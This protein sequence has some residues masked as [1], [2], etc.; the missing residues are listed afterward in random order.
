MQLTRNQQRHWNWYTPQVFPNFRP[1]RLSRRAEP[2]DSEDF[3]FEI[4]HD[5]FRALAFIENGQCRLVSRNGN[6]FTRFTG[7]SE[8]IGERIR[9]DAVID[10]EIACLDEAGRA[11]FNVLLFNRGEC[12]FL[13][14]DLLFLNGDD[15]R[16]LPLIER[17][18]RLKRLVGRHKKGLLYVDHVERT[19]CALFQR[20]CALDLEGIVAK[21]KD[22]PYRATEKPSSHWIKIK[23]P[24][25]T[26]SVGRADLF[27]RSLVQG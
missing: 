13:A 27:E 22:A 12:V 23:N 4:K 10:G 2:F 7:L 15:L 6:T 20:M 8:W 1:V 14:F 25:Y 16:D 9:T 19:G 5:G 26:Q 18:R 17:K 21:R 24:D 11:M 3:I